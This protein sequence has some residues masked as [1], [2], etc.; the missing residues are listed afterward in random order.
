MT[1]QPASPELVG[2]R[3]VAAGMWTARAT[4]TQ[5]TTTAAQTPEIASRLSP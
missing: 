5:A 1:P 2:A 4:G 3:C